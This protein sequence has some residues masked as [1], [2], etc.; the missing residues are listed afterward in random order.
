MTPRML[1]YTGSGAVMMSE[2]VAGS[3]AMMAPPALMDIGPWLPRSR[4]MPL[5]LPRPPPLP[6]SPSPKDEDRPDEDELLS[7]NMLPPLLR[8]RLLLPKLLSEPLLLPFDSPESTACS[9]STSLVA[10]AFFR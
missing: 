2:L 9:T 6:L 1:R 8:L 10:S 7:P 5:W 3:A 4:L